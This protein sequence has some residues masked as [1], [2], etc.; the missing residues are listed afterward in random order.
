MESSQLLANVSLFRDLSA[1]ELERVRAL[2]V[3][4]HYVRTQTLFSEGQTREA[5]YFIRKGLIKISKVDVEGREHIVNLLGRGE[6]FPHVGFFTDDPY[7]GTA[8]AVEHSDVL[9]IGCAA[10]DR[11]LMDDPLI[12][13]KVM[14]VMGERIVQLQTK[15]QDLFISNS[16]ERV[17]TLLRHLIE[18]H[19]RTQHDGVHLRLS[20]T[21]SEMA[22]MIGMTRESV[23]R[24]W[25]ELRRAGVITGDRGEWIVYPE[26][27]P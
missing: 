16:H 14:R 1:E 23:N 6:M 13:R 20:I 27:L 2:C 10:F 18:E 7:P 8:Q 25:N 4:H 19:G 5:V 11:L 3:E 12:A 24:V 15:V 17:L 9:A 21:N 26:R 22:M